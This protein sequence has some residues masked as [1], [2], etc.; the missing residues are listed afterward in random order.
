MVGWGLPAEWS[1]RH[2]VEGDDGRD[3]LERVSANEF[4][5][6]LWSV[7]FS[8]NTE[9]WILNRSDS[10]KNVATHRHIKTFWPSTITQNHHHP[11]IQRSSDLLSSTIYQGPMHKNST[12]YRCRRSSRWSSPVPSESLIMTPRDTSLPST[13]DKEVDTRYRPQVR[14]EGRRVSFITSRG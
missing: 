8:V 6:A 5:G 1:A 11:S 2:I 14:Y 9:H 13:L 4:S 3:K 7:E 12:R 10:M